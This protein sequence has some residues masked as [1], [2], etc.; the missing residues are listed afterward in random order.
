MSVQFTGRP[1]PPVTAE[2][3]EWWDA[4][5]DRV[6]TVQRCLRCENVQLYPRVICTQ[7]G[8][9]ELELVPASGRAV[10]YSHTTVE[11]S[12]NPEFFAPP[13]TVALVRLEEGPTMLTNI[14]NAD[15]HDELC[16]RSVTVTWEALA[17]GRQ[18][19]LFTLTTE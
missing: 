18:L 9:L 17:D 11:K 14:V 10:V 6:L 3:A 5:R 13:Y 12:A 2:T 4:T 15:P 1:V 19:P 8:S 7:C 16:D